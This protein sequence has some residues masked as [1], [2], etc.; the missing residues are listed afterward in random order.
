M[1]SDKKNRLGELLLA[2][3]WI[4]NEELR[5]ALGEQQKN[6]GRLGK[7][8]REKGMVA[9]D[10][11]LDTL[12]RQVGIEIVDLSQGVENPEAISSMPYTI[13]KRYRALPLRKEEKILHI[14]MTEP[15]DQ[16]AI[17]ALQ[18][19]TG[20]R[21]KPYFC[22]D[23]EIDI[24][25]EQ[26]YGMEKA[27]DAIVKNVA[28]EACLE[29]PGK[30]SMV[31]IEA[32]G[33]EEEEARGKDDSEKSVAPIV[34]LVNLIF[35]EAA[36]KEASDIHFEPGRQ[37]L[38]VRFRLDGLLRRRMSI[39]KY[40]QQPVLS[41]IKIMAR[42]DI[43]NKRSPQDGGIRLLADENRL[44]LRVSSLPTFYGEKIVIRLLDQTEKKIDLGVLGLN[45][46]DRQQLELCYRR[47]QGMILV[48]GPTGSGKSTTLQCILKDLRS[49]NVNIIT[50]EDPVEY[51]IEGI[52]QVQVHREAGLT[53][54]DSLRAILRQDPNII[55]IGE[56]RDSET[57]EVAFRAALTGHL[58]LSTLHTNDTVSTITRLVDMQVPPFL[59]S[60]ALLAVVSQR[61]ARKI[62]PGCRAP[63]K[64]DESLLKNLPYNLSNLDSLQQGQGCSQCEQTGYKGRV[65]I[66]ELLFFTPEI[67]ELVAQGATEGEIRKK[68]TAQGMGS[69]LE[70]GI[71][72]IFK[73]ATTLEE[74]ISVGYWEESSTSDSPGPLS[75]SERADSSEKAKRPKAKNS[76]SRPTIVFS[77]DDP[78]IR[79]AVCLTLEALSCH[80]ITAVDGQEG[81]EKIQAHLPDLI[82]SDIQMPRLDGYGLLKKV[83]TDLQTAF[84]PVILLTAKNRCE[85]RMKGFLSGG[86]D[87]IEKPFNHRELLVRVKRCLERNAVIGGK[88]GPQ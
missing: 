34:R 2:G 71:N 55:M 42:M 84:I 82:I 61:L 67:R 24:S 64:A 10:T 7:I 6:K 85:D 65:G 72:K 86:D 16:E 29:D 81:W 58:V 43:A 5:S 76:S 14:A 52:N 66:Y 70:D 73:G 41:R 46:Q 56:I 11:L 83:R 45:E 79:E 9:E 40:L 74:V 32:T 60:S 8:L 68:A 23:R 21:I 1:M 80:V 17:Q 31:D 69:L 4:T 44:D 75:A 47:P 33:T 51:E 26:H 18:F 28:Q 19:A 3:G 88:A 38:Q 13:A 36:R 50:V 63:G 27:L 30:I 20:M 25:I 62:C 39:P 87:Y 57:A 22:S 12:S 48:T 35:L 49:E 15:Q 37:Y 77:D 59:I 78:A 54:A 53:F